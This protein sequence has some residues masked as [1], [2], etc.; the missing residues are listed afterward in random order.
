M[1]KC[2]C[3]SQTLLR[4]AS[5]GEAYWFCTSCRQEMPDLVSLVEAQKRRHQ[6]ES[7]GEIASVS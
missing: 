7:L 1:N 3:C 5:R 4:Y 2:P 6:L